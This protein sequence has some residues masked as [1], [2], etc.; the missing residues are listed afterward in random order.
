MWMGQRKT[1]TKPKT[2]R[3]SLCSF[4]IDSESVVSDCVSVSATTITSSDATSSHS[5]SRGK[6]KPKPKLSCRMRLSLWLTRA[7]RLGT[8]ALVALL[9][10]LVWNQENNYVLHNFGRPEDV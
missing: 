8:V 10:L 6:P 7:T 2:T 4:R 3:N 1:K 9:G 5:F